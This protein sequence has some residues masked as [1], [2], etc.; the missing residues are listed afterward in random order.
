MSKRREPPPAPEPRWTL[1]NDLQAVTVGINW[2]IGDVKKAGMVP[3]LIKLGKLH[4]RLFLREHHLSAVPREPWAYSNA[5]IPVQFNAPGIVG[6]VVEGVPKP[7]KSKPAS[8][9]RD[10]TTS[11]SEGS[12]PPRGSAS[13]RGRDT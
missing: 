1:R 4:T 5:K 10:T 7:A 11:D 9:R 2:R 6:I 3:S 12:S 13:D 8:A